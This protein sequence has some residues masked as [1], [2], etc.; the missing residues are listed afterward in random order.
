LNNDVKDTEN[1]RTCSEEETVKLRQKVDDLEKEVF[2]LLE[3]KSHLETA[4][5][6][7]DYEVSSVNNDYVKSSKF[8]RFAA[9]LTV[10][11]MKTLRLAKT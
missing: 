9:R 3:K 8:T 7:K 11:A 10:Y 6:S 5:G 4:L 2:D 1:L